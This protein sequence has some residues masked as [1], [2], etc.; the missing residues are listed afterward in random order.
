MVS[1]SLSSIVLPQRPADL[2]LANSEQIFVSTYQLRQS[3]H[4]EGTIFSIDDEFKITNH[5]EV[6]AGVFRFDCSED[7]TV[8]AA[9]TNGSICTAPID[10]SS[11]TE[12][13]VAHPSK[14]LLTSCVSHNHLLTTDDHGAAYVVDLN[15]PH[16][17]TS[18]EAHK[19]PYTGS[20]CE[21][22]S[23]CW[24]SEHFIATGGEDASIKFW[25]LR[26]LGAPVLVNNSHTYGVVSLNPESNTVLLSGSYDEVIQKIDI[27]SPLNP[28]QARKMNGGVW[29]MELHSDFL[30]VSCMYGGWQ[31]IEKNSL[32]D[33][34]SNATLGEHLLY[35]AAFCP[36][37][38]IISSCT[39][40][41][42][43]VNFD[44]IKC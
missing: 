14:M 31:M 44:K 15:Q 32:N 13:S 25:D 4:R 42:Y 28:T 2:H 12:I 1:E 10:L 6:P 37:S 17:I 5:L 24:I 43:S 30:L 16:S 35:G 41:N 9:L 20:A 29:N 21:V 19:L 22:W 33:I 36:Q 7:G 34:E 8:V 11:Y 3:D 26:C 38:S 27:K 23:A 39:F 18:F 40:N